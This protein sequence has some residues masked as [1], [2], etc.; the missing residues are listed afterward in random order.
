MSRR[1]TY[2]PAARLVSELRRLLLLLLLAGGSAV[3]LLLTR[4][5]ATG[6]RDLVGEVE[7][8]GPVLDRDLP[9]AVPRAPEVEE[10]LQIRGGVRAADQHQYQR[11]EETQHR[12]GN[13]LHGKT[14]HDR[15]CRGPITAGLPIPTWRWFAARTSLP[16][17]SPGRRRRGGVPAPA[18][19][20]LKSS[21]HTTTPNA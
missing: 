20:G 11:R 14:E 18:S 13:Q 1:E 8:A 10:H 15:D 19:A 3:L 5:A 9:I 12:P 17:W 6:H 7:G 21:S 2:D 16:Q 4:P